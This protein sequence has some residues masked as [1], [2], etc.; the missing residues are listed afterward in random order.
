MS[1]FWHTQPVPQPG[2]SCPTGEI[3]ALDAKDEPV[4]LPDG[5]TWSTC[6]H[7]ELTNFMEH[8]YLQDREMNLIYNKDTL[9]WLLM[10]T[11]EWGRI[12]LRDTKNKLVGYITAT[13]SH[14]VCEG[15][16]IQTVFINLLCVHKKSRAKGLAPE[17]IKEATRRAVSMGITQAIYTAVARLPTPV[18]RGTFLHRIL[19]VEN[20][21]ACGFFTSARPVKNALDVRGRSFMREIDEADLPQVQ[22]LLYVHGTNFKLTMKPTEEYARWLLPRRGVVHSYISEEGDK[23]VSFYRI[24]YRYKQSGVELEMAYLMHAIGK[25]SVHDAVILAK[26]AGYDVLNS[27]N[28]GSRDLDSNKFVEGHSHIHYYLYNWKPGPLTPQDV[29]VILP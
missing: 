16:D 21:R 2:K 28:I 7:H 24:G 9:S 27:I 1:Q 20:T 3:R 23:F 12:A 4:N 19:N 22:R 11:P 26:N 13:P 29:E 8:H 17:L 25:D 5:F 18:I 15:K 6:T 14:V 10:M